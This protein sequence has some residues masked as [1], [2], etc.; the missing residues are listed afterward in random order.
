[1]PVGHSRTRAWSRYLLAGFFI[2]AGVNHFLQPNF[3]LPLIPDYLPWPISLNLISGVAEIVLGVGML[4]NHLQS[5]AMW[6]LII[7]L[8]LFIPS[9]IYFIRV[10]SCIEGGLCAPM[11]MAWLRLVLIH[12]L[13]LLWVWYSG[14][15]QS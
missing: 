10:G 5:A 13:L 11:W 2:L 9:H 14:R 15:V 8:I 1:M 3:Y 6:G 4:I 7:L 12:P